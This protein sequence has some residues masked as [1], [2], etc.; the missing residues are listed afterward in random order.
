[1][2]RP[3]LL[4]V[5]VLTLLLGACAGAGSPDP[6]DSITDRSHRY[7]EVL[8]AGFVITPVGLADPDPNAAAISSLLTQQ[9]YTALFV[10]AGN[11]P[12]VG[13]EEAVERIRV[14]GEEGV[15]AFRDFR[16]DRI[17]D[18]PLDPDACVAMS[19]LLLHRYALVTW[20]E[21]KEEQG[22]EEIDR[23]YTEVDFADDVRRAAFRRVRGT[24]RGEIVDLWEAE[25]MWAASS[26]YTTGRMFGDTGDALAELQRSR[27]EGVLDLVTMIWTP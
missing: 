5:L 7:H 9:L 17:L 3:P 16:Q 4:P 13:P 18:R 11:T 24:V 27:D 19:R 12:V 8:Q 26:T 15:E 21:E 10:S 6:E 1:M 2:P 25:T 22:M 14:D 20:I 23:D